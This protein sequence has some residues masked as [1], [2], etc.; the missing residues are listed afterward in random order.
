MTTPES[1]HTRKITSFS[2]AK[3]AASVLA[4]RMR[5]HPLTRT[6]FKPDLKTM[7]KKRNNFILY[8]YF[9]R[10]TLFTTQIRT[11][12]VAAPKMANCNKHWKVMNLKDL[13]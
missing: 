9:A 4:S 1:F 6:L 8:S 11:L 7:L 2:V 10:R 12:L 3:I 5:T 13:I